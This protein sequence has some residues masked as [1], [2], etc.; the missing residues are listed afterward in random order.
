MAIQLVASIRAVTMAVAALESSDDMALK[1]TYKNEERQ[2][3][4]NSYRVIGAGESKS[5]AAGDVGRKQRRRL[6]NCRGV[7]SLLILGRPI[8]M[9]AEKRDIWQDGCSDI[10][11]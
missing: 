4:I 3:K 8:V 1:D 6:R 5:L 2:G 11:A 9:L 10:N 7:E